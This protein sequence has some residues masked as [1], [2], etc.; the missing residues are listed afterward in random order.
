LLSVTAVSGHAGEWVTDAV[1]GCQVWN[2]GPQANETFSWSGA[3]KDGKAFGTGTQRIFQKG[4]LKATRT[5]DFLDGKCNGAGMTTWATGNRHEGNYVDGVISGKGVYIWVNGNRYEGDF[6]DGVRT[7][8]GVLIWANGDRYAGDFVHNEPTGKG[9]IT[10]TNGISL[11]GN[12]LNGKISGKGIAVSSNGDRY[13]GEFVDNL[14]TGKG[15]LLRSNGDRYIGDFQGDK[16]T[17]KVVSTSV[18]GSRYEMTYIQGEPVGKTVVTWSD[19]TR[20]ETDVADS[21]PI[22]VKKDLAPCLQIAPEYPASALALPDSEPGSTGLVKAKA[23]VE[24]GVVRAV[25]VLSRPAIFHE[26]V[27]SAM[28]KYTCPTINGPRE[29]TQEF[30][31]EIQ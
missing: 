31:F 6:V 11:E 1:S 17:G 13:V 4:S 3:C 16:F 22:D 29:L 24:N 2:A 12:F 5:C 9:V 27:R 20:F 19:G 28:L 23:L 8:K 18:V 7:G 10:G 14:P 15:D 30:K 25:E 21:E 26:A